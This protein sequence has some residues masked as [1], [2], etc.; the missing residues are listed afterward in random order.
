M[1]S[2]SEQLLKDSSVYGLG[3]ICSKLVSFISII[4]YTRIFSISEFGE[5]EIL[6]TFGSLLT[7]ISNLGMDSTLSRFYFEKNRGKRRPL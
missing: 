4:I 5:I 2:R 3:E 6:V 1:T 7:S